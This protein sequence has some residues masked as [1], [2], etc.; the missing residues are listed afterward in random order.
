VQTL[1]DNLGVLAPAWGLRPKVVPRQ[2]AAG[3]EEA[4][5]A[6]EEADAAE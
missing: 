1:G 6:A 4:A 3:E 5:G 2:T